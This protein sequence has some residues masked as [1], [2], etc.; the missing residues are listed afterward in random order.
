[1]VL[2]WNSAEHRIKIKWSAAKSDPTN[3]GYS[4]DT[5][6]K[7]LQKYA[8]LEAFVMSSKR[9]GSAMVEFKTQDGA[10]MAVAYEKGLASNPLTLEWI[11]AAPR[12]KVTGSSTVSESDFE[13]IVLRQMRQA[14]ER[15]RLIE[16]MQKED[17]AS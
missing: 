5:L 16:E 4:S 13:S 11:G 2:D 17:E 14:E 8:D 6:R 9:N 7:F 15:K 3:G 10:E 1:M 12:S